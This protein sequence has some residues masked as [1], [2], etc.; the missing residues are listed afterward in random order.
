[1][2]L[3]RTSEMKPGGIRSAG[4]EL[5]EELPWAAG[6]LR[7]RVA[8]PFSCR[9]CDGFRELPARVGAASI[10]G[11]LQGLPAALISLPLQG[12]G[13]RNES[14]LTCWSTSPAS[15]Q[16]R[17]RLR[18]PSV[19][20]VAPSASSLHP[21][22]TQLAQAVLS[23]MPPNL[24]ACWKL[25]L[26]SSCFC[27]GHALGQAASR[28]NCRTKGSACSLCNQSNPAV[29]WLI[30]AR[31]WKCGDVQVLQ[32]GEPIMLIMR[33]LPRSA[34]CFGSFSVL[35]PEGFFWK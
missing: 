28:S 20:C 25:L 15:Q 11:C 14:G 31:K 9:V 3:Q 7:V 6:F 32:L 12:C 4:A 29:C 19:V 24:F 8:L 35:K 21:N 5:A 2:R 23:L 13:H 16:P 33:S 30:G 26:R 10:S 27:A 22:S 17:A 1:M 18:L 34:G